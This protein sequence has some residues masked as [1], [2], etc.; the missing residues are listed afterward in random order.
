[1]SAWT[2]VEIA[3][4]A[5][6]DDLHVAPY[7]PAGTITGTPTWI[8]SVVVDGRLFVRAWNG[9]SSSWY[10][11]AIVQRAGRVHTMGDVFEV[12][13]MP[14]DPRLQARIDDAYRGKYTGSPYLP[15]MLRSGP[16]SA[17]VEIT[18]RRSE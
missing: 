16:R 13:F 6:S 18:P 2:D 8:W 3:R 12:D 17:S 10:R 15:P 9:P 11:A 4:M 5:A 1:V 14:A 7:R